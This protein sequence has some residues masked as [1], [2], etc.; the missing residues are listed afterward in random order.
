MREYLRVAFNRV[1]IGRSRKHPVTQKVHNLIAAPARFRLDHD[2]YAFPVELWAK[3]A[4]AKLLT[5]PK[6]KVDAHQLSAEA[7]AC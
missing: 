5:P 1:P 7:V 6:S 4:A 3:S 2:C